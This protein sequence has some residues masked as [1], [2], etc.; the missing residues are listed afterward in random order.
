LI[1]PENTRIQL[2]SRLTEIGIG[3]CAVF[4]CLA[5]YPKVAVAPLATE[6]LSIVG[7]LALR[8]AIRRGAKGVEHVLLGSCVLILTSF[9]DGFTGIDTTWVLHVPVAL[10][11]WILVESVKGRVFWLSMQVVSVAL[12]NLT[13]LTPHLDRLANPSG[14]KWQYAINL[15]AAMTASIL[16]VRYLMKLQEATL[17]EVQEQ[18][19]QAEAASRAKDEFLSHMSHELRTPLNAIQGFADLTVQSASISSENLDNLHSIQQ[20]AAYLTHLVNDILDLARLENGS[21]ALARGGFS[22]EACIE[23]VLDLVR[24][25]AKE[26][27]LLV[28]WHRQVE[29]PRV[30]GDRVRWKQILLNLVANAVKYTKEGS[31]EV[32]GEWNSTGEDCGVLTCR[33]KDT[34]IGIAPHDQERIFDR[35]QRLGGFDA[36]SGTGLGLAISTN[37]AR[38]MG[39]TISLESTVGFGSTF[40]MTLPFRTAPPDSASL[41]SLSLRVPSDL[42]GFRIL[43][44]EDN[45]V[46]IKLATQVLS[47][48][49]A[50]FDVAEDGI[51]ALDL[52]C[53]NHY[54]LLLL[55]L[56][57]PGKDGF[58]VAQAIRDPTSHVPN[59][60]I[61]I[62]ALTAD[63]FE[64]TRQRALQAG[65][66]DFLSKPFRIID[67]CD[68]ALRLVHGRDGAT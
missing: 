49:H 46:N 35:F 57:M 17:V 50:Q 41:T 37:L 15:A 42:R 28:K 14:A 5:V 40:T 25:A 20:S 48:L 43:L 38:A 54:D 26:K 68:K 45:R 51:K 67:L 59:K 24:P 56:H 36:P 34:G 2:V 53:R 44:A 8:T 23:E 18:R 32:S 52:L 10:V 58:E 19:K 64:E 4:M 62:L 11:A 7:F 55:D 6:F 47:R 33:V 21:L 65:M 12:V 22:P 1:L 13:D 63:A 29:L 31:V 30:M 3:I 66:D 60:R 9:D 61:P 27:N 39:G 16:I